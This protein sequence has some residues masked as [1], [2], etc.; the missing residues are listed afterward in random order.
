MKF[1]MIGAAVLLATVSAAPAMAQ[2][3]TTAAPQKAAA[4]ATV[5]VS[6][7]AGPAIADLQ[8]AVNAKDNASI[9]A[10]LAAAKSVAS[11]KNDHYLIARLELQYAAAANDSAA[12]AEAIDALAQ[13][14]MMQPKEMADLYNALGGTYFGAKQYDQAV[15]AFQH[16]MALDPHNNDALVMIAQSRVAQGRPA[17][18]LSALQQAIQ[19]STAAGQKPDEALYQRSVA[20]AYKGKLANAP[21]IARAWL[22]AYPSPSSWHDAIAIY[23][24]TV[25]TDTSGT[26]DLLRLMRV[27]GSLTSPEDFTAYVAAAYD[28]NNFAEAQAVLAEG[29]AANKIE[30]SSPLIADVKAKPAPTLADLAAAARTAQ[31]GR[32]LIGIGDRY[33]GLGEYAKAADTYR[34]AI[35]KGGDTNLANLQL[36]MALA[37]AGDKAGAISALNAV[38]GANAGVAKFWLLYLQQHG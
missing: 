28:Q 36:G 18:A 22:V 10:K 32:G 5:Q 2:S 29:L 24:S 23:R 7:Q 20:I 13:S 34:Q 16:Q 4:A 12:A 3:G 38:G 25:P 35:A 33:Y 30:A 21:D 14:G 15:T 1:S 17:D 9:P 27:S 37:R 26:L 11:T 8:K 6:K 31:S 19:A